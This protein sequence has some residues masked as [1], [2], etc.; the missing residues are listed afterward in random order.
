MTSMNNLDMRSLLLLT[1]L[2]P[3]FSQRSFNCVKSRTVVP[4]K[5]AVFSISTIFPFSSE[6]LIY[7]FT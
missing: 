3:Y 7:K 5:D 2:S 4:H 1:S 6:K